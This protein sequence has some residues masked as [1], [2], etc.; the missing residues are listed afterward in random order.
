MIREDHLFK[1]LLKKSD[2]NSNEYVPCRDTPISKQCIAA[3]EEV[4][5][6]NNDKLSILIQQS[7][8]VETH[9]DPVVCVFDNSNKEIISQIFNFIDTMG[10]KDQ[11]TA[12]E[13][14]R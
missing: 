1:N 4:Y 9:L 6:R 5:K 3:F 14:E 8:L 7:E 12:D 2:V 11:I 13:I 10:G